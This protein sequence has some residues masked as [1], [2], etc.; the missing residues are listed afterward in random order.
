MA[1]KK[2][3]LINKSFW[4]QWFEYECQLEKDAYYNKESYSIFNSK[5]QEQLEIDEKFNYLCI[6]RTVDYM[7][8]FNVDIKFIV[9]LILEGLVPRLIKDVS[10]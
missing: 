9:Q 7:N 2:Q 6:S 10:L 4:E 5:S 3:I 8:C 1:K